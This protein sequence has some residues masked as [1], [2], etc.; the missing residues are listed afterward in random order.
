MPTIEAPVEVVEHALTRADLYIN[1]ELSWIEFTRRVLEDAADPR[2]PLLE[3]VKFLSIYNSNLDEFFMIRVS[4]L[5]EQVQSG[6]TETG[7][8]GPTASGQLAATGTR[9]GQHITQ[10]RA[11]PTPH[12]TPLPA[13]P[14]LR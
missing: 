5:K 12:R 1:R 9:S 4:G 14:A 6:V 7:P 8:D 10:Q 2:H 3:R 13:R 11:S